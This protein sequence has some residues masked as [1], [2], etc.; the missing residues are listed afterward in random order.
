VTIGF[1]GTRKGMN[2]SQRQQLSHVLLW[3]CKQ[4]VEFHHGAAIGADSE[5][6]RAARGYEL[7]VV[8]H[9]AGREPLKRNREIVNIVNLLIAAPETD[10]EELRSGTWATVRYARA[11]GVP[12]VMLSRG[13]S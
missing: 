3:L 9:P 10:R 7:V 13:K 1:T 11:E 5:A 12:V 8:T 4:C 2:E 6:D